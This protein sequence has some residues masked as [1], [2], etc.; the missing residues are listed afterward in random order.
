[1]G[2]VKS[3]EEWLNNKGVNAC[4]PSEERVTKVNKSGMD[5]DAFSE[6]IFVNDNVKV[7]DDDLADDDAN[8]RALSA[9]NDPASHL[10]PLIPGLPES[11]RL[12]K[13]SRKKK[14]RS[15]L[16]KDSQE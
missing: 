13:K 9:E 7:T 4:N 12:K 3:K 16:W 2:N 14:K 1:M 6:M 5:A 8:A 15:V 10:K 11:E